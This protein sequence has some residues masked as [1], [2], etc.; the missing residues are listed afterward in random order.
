MNKVGYCWLSLILWWLPGAALAQ[1]QIAWLSWQDTEFSHFSGANAIPIQRNAYS[2]QYR[3][4][5][6]PRQQENLFTY[7]HEPVLVRDLTPAHN[8]YFHR[9]DYTTQRTIHEWEG[10]VSLGLHG[11]SNMFNH[12][13][14]H[15]DA[16]V[17]TGYLRRSW[18]PCGCKIGLHG[19]Y[20][21]GHFAIYPTA[22]W[23]GTIAKVLTMEIS[24]PYLFK[25]ADSAKRWELHLQRVGNKWGALDRSR[26]IKSAYYLEEWQVEAQLNVLHDFYGSDIGLI[27]GVSFDTTIRYLDLTTGKRKEELEPAWYAGLIV[28]F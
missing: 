28:S 20:R 17:L 13:Q 5:D 10:Q 6:E 22:D 24:L 4:L 15:R 11:S 14:F 23:R 16:V 8:G 3:W 19:D 1:W 9:L 2:L 27:M 7:A 25:L 21:F 12:A 18:I 26:E